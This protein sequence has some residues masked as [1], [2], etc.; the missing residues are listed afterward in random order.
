MSIICLVG[1]IN[2]QTLNK[3][4]DKIESIEDVKSFLEDCSE[5]L[6]LDCQ[7]SLL[8]RIKK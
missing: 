1:E 5:L 6:F 8:R 2:N 7:G 4:Y 3:N